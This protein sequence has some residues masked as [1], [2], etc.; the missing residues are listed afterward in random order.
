MDFVLVGLGK[1]ARCDEDLFGFI[2]DFLD[3]IGTS[4][5]GRRGSYIEHEKHGNNKG[6]KT[7]SYFCQRRLIYEIVAMEYQ[8]YG[9]IRVY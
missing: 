1:P 3:L 2:R 4:K 8:K 7:Q 6:N 9:T 5:D